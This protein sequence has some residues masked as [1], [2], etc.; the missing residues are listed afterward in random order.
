MANPQKSFNQAAAKYCPQ[1]P[2]AAFDYGL[3]MSLRHSY[4][5]VETP[6]V[7]CSSIKSTLLRLELDDPGFYRVDFE[8]VHNRAFSPLLKPSQIGDL[9][10]FLARSSIFKFCFVRN[11]YSR[12]LSA[13]LDKI[14]GN[15]KQKAQVLLQLGHDPNR[16]DREISFEKFVRAVVAQPVSVM[17]P[18]WR[19]VLPDVSGG[20]HV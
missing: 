2:V 18:H 15:R 11:P 13:W 7:A 8:D 17:D 19:A 4:V 10:Q 20:A 14:A 12:L 9:D 3:N 16:L 5:Y 1:V 6:K